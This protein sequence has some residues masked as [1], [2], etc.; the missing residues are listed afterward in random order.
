MRDTTPLLKFLTIGPRYLKKQCW[1]GFVVLT[2]R[3]RT[4]ASPCAFF[5]IIILIKLK[6]YEL[7]GSFPCCPVRIFYPVARTEKARA[8]LKSEGRFEKQL[9]VPLL[10]SLVSR[11]SPRKKVSPGG[12]NRWIVAFALASDVRPLLPLLLTRPRQ[13]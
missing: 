5:F 9:S 2:V 8:N 7:N 1:E 10:N 3:L 13:H 11:P 12:G 4:F 6:S